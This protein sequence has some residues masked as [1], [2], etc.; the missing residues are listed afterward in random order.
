L[1]NRKGFAMGLYKDKDV[2]IKHELAFEKLW[3]DKLPRL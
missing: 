2:A 1:K 3:R